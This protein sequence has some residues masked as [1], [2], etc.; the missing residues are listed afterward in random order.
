MPSS[1]EAAASQRLGWRSWL[2]GPRKSWALAWLAV[3]G[4]LVILYTPGTP[5]GALE[6]PLLPG[7]DK[8]IHALAFGLPVYLFGRLVKRAWLI[9]LVFAVHAA[10]SEVIQG[11]LIPFRDPDVW[12]GVADLI[13]I[14]LALLLLWSSHRAERSAT[15]GPVR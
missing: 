5:D 11:T 4:Q 12:D 8:V 7:V 2:T 13:G 15:S 9:G 10:L 1:P 3:V 14:G 6:L